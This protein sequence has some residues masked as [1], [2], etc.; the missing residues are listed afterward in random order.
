MNFWPT[1]GVV[2]EKWSER[3]DS[4][5]RPLSPQNR[6]TGQVLEFARAI[7][8]FVRVSFLIDSG[9]LLATFGAPASTTGRDV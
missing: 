4:N 8:R 7:A 3:R 6:N 5:P 9:Q 2:R 1:F